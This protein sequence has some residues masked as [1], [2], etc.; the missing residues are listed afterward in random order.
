M[1]PGESAAGSVGRVGALE[2][3]G[4]IGEQQGEGDERVP[5]VQ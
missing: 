2:A 5:S 4:P 3:H 1:Q